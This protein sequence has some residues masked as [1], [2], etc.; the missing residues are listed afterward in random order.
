MNT[1]TYLTLVIT[2]RCSAR[3]DHCCLGAGPEFGDWMSPDDAERYISGVTRHNTI[4]HMTLIGGEALLDLDRTVAIGKIALRC[5]IHKVDVDTNGSW[6]TNDQAARHVLIT[7]RNA[8]LNVSGISVDAFHQQHV[9]RE[10]ALC[11]MRAAKALGLDVQGSSEILDPTNP[12]NTYDERTQRLAEWFSRHGFS[13]TPGGPAYVVFQ[14]RATNL[15]H[16]HTGPRSIPQDKCAGVPWFATA[17]FRR[18]GGIEIDPY[19]WVMVEHGLCIG[20]ARQRP[21]KDILASYDPAAHPILS[22]LMADGPIGLT[23]IPE[24]DGFELREEGYIDKCHLC[25][26]IRT[27]L[28]SRFPNL[29]APE[30]CYP[31]I[32]S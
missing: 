9:P 15:A 1:L 24:A 10:H 28:R 23:R 12:S 31:E 30:N 2:Y 11:A 21:V 19:G 25:H 27:H 26:E 5:G 8:G 13:V 6:A 20:N 22:V 7:L 17:D 4:S 16:A 32:T 14:G 18:L 3:C 29:L